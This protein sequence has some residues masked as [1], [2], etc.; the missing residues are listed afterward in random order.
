MED[1]RNVLKPIEPAYKYKGEDFYNMR[2]PNTK[3]P[4]EGYYISKSGKILS[5][6]TSKETLIT[7]RKGKVS[8]YAIPGITSSYSV[9]LLLAD[10]FLTDVSAREKYYLKGIMFTREYKGVEDW[11]VVTKGSK[12]NPTLSD[13]DRLTWQQYKEYCKEHQVTRSVIKPQD[14]GLIR[15]IKE[16][17]NYSDRKI[18]RILKVSNSTVIEACTG[19]SHRNKDIDM[20]YDILNK[21]GK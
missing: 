18:G 20:I 17:T 7:I 3:E 12:N 21:G 4:L 11:Y 2:D 8:L 9:S 5:V 10:T 14:K 15:R 13:V 19:K 6:K 1:F 16:G